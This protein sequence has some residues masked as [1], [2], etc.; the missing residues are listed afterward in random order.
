MS[1]LYC[2]S[3]LWV[4]ILFVMN[5]VGFKVGLYDET[6]LCFGTTVCIL[7]FFFEIKILNKQASIQNLDVRSP[8]CYE[9]IQK[10]NKKPSVKRIIDSQR[11]IRVSS[12]SNLLILLYR[13]KNVIQC[14]Y[15]SWISKEFYWIRYE[16]KVWFLSSYFH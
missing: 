16:N 12:G 15:L 8:L 3:I 2:Q 14:K 7:F 10:H 9:E 11:S 1:C 13:R 6:W 4:N 5:F